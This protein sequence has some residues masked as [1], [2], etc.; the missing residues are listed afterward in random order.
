MIYYSY[1]THKSSKM[2]IPKPYSITKINKT[3]ANILIAT[4][5]SKDTVREKN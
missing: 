3:V 5:L 2:I 1:K 4:P